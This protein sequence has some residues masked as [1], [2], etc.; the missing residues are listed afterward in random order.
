MPVQMRGLPP[1]STCDPFKPQVAAV[2]AVAAAAKQK[3]N[4]TAKGTSI[5]F[6]QPWTITI[7][8]GAFSKRLGVAGMRCPKAPKVR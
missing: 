2:A 1:S 7:K 6:V 4:K 5:K 8:A 3:H